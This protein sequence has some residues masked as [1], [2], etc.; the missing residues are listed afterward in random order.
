[1]MSTA[2]CSSG[3]STL[4]EFQIL[5]ACDIS[6]VADEALKG[7]SLA[8]AG[9]LLIA[10]FLVL[11][12]RRSLGYKR[13]VALT[14]VLWTALQNVIMPIRPLV[15]IFTTARAVNNI[16][17]RLLA[18]AEASS[19][20]MVSILFLFLEMRLLHRTAIKQTPMQGCF[21][22]AQDVLSKRLTV[23]VVASVLQ[24]IF[25]F[26]GALASWWWPLLSPPVAFWAPVVIVVNTVI[27][28]YCALALII[29]RRI[30][31]SHSRTA[32]RILLP[33]LACT[34]LGGLAGFVGIFCCVGSDPAVAEI[35]LEIVWIASLLYSALLFYIT[36]AK[37]SRQRRVETPTPQKSKSISKDT[38]T[39]TTTSS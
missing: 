22:I 5:G 35:L 32:R 9:V 16:F 33:V 4:T 11:L 30:R 8:L 36:S 28:C 29:W 15:G 31:R 10:E 23:A 7:T 38:G 27:I 6:L 26:G 3:F 13:N 20:S 24:G 14:L 2:N 18:A 12:R 19:T 21:G 39:T 34:A 37:T 1:M 17:M 25:F